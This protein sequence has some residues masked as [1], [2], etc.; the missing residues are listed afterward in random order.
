MQVSNKPWVYILQEYNN[1]PYTLAAAGNPVSMGKA[2][3]SLL[4]QQGF[5]NTNYQIRIIK[6]NK[7]VQGDADY[8]TLYLIVD[9]GIKFPMYNNYGEN[10]FN[11]PGFNVAYLN[12]FNTVKPIIRYF[13][14][15]LVP[16]ILTWVG[17]DNYRRVGPL[18]LGNITSQNSPPYTN[19]ETFNQGYAYT[20]RETGCTNYFSLLQKYNNPGYAYTEYYVYQNHVNDTS[21]YIEDEISVILKEMQAL[22]GSN[23]KLNDI[24]KKYPKEFIK[25]GNFL[26]LMYRQYATNNIIIS[27]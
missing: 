11:I 26:L 7:S 5:N 6:R 21:L 20:L 17:T 22:K 10:K 2:L 25:Y 27:N 4:N 9:G 1:P 8:F 3:K 23:K 14:F 24:I 18:Q 16:L 13:N 12:N 15:G 19:I